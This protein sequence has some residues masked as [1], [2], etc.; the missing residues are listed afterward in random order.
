[1]LVRVFS[2]LSGSAT[3]S[4]GSVGGSVGILLHATVRVRTIPSHTP[5]TPRKRLVAPGSWPPVRWWVRVRVKGWGY[6]ARVIVR[7]GSKD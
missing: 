3:R 2:L 6:R 4:G 7:N 5:A 1:M